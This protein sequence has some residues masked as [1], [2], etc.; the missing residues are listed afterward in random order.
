M[1]RWPMICK[2]NEIEMN[3]EMNELV[4]VHETNRQTLI[5]EVNEMKVTGQKCNT[6]DF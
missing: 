1:W 2:K 4:F 6:I 5:N 3:D